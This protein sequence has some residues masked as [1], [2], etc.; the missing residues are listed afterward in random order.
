MQI[1]KQYEAAYAK[2]RSE[3]HRVQEI[4]DRHRHA[5]SSPIRSLP[6]DL[7]A[8]IFELAD[9]NA[10]SMDSFPW[11]ATRVCR[12]WRVVARSHQ[13]LWATFHLRSDYGH[14][15]LES[16]VRSQSGAAGWIAWQDVEDMR[17]GEEEVILNKKTFGP[18]GT[19]KVISEALDF[20]KNVP[21]TL[22]FT[23]TDRSPRYKSDLG[24]EWF[25]IFIR[26]APRWKN[27]KLSLGPFFAKR[28]PLI[29]GRLYMLE[30]LDLELVMV[31]GNEYPSIL[32]DVFMSAPCLRY[33]TIS[34]ELVF[35]FPWN[36]L[37]HFQVRY[38]SKWKDYQALL[39]SGPSLE[40]L[41]TDFWNFE[42]NR[43]EGDTDVS[44]S[45]PEVILPRLRFLESYG[46]PNRFLDS[47]TLPALMHITRIDGSA[48]PSLSSM[49][50]RS[51]CT[52]THLKLL[53]VTDTADLI[54]LL[55]LCLSLTSLRIGDLLVEEPAFFNAMAQ[56]SYIV[57]LL[58]DLHIHE[59]TCPLECGTQ[60]VEML[61]ARQNHLKVF[62][63]TSIGLGKV[64]NEGEY[65]WIGRADK[66]R[67]QELYRLGMEIRIG[68]YWYHDYGD[69]R[70]IRNSHVHLSEEDDVL[71]DSDYGLLAGLFDPR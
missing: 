34:A 70:G 60:M 10:A 16:V 64:G 18:T 6:D 17:H 31:D 58:R 29:R 67:L 71:S 51:N 41:K 40:T 49:I 65:E 61:I 9:P 7:L 66:A 56:S 15:D 36:Q 37:R 63:I 32:V 46:I 33:V 24:L 28:L 39:Q 44:I 11:V 35:T 48:I 42:A 62:R 30:S 5:L 1:L 14:P 45:Y 25:D 3:Q 23:V 22:F 26:N 43:S 50:K 4:M 69:F 12:Q 19:T 13:I 54:A 47:A 38:S 2:T 27:V 53:R 21:I 20:S 59:A 52:L 55:R 57:P 68:R 8:V